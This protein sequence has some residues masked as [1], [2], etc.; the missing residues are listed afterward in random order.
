VRDCVVLKTPSS[1]PGPSLTRS[2]PRA[3]R[4]VWSLA[5]S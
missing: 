2:T 4:A 1:G 5:M 3:N